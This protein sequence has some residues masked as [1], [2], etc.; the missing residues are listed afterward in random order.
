MTDIIDHLKRYPNDPSLVLSRARVDEIISEIE[1]LRR[2]NAAMKETLDWQNRT[3]DL[4]FMGN[5]K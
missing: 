4:D 3:S 1:R 5:G 2:E